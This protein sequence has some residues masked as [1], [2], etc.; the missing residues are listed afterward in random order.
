MYLIFTSFDRSDN[1]QKHFT[2]EKRQEVVRYAFQMS[3]LKASTIYRIPKSTVKQ[4]ME[5]ERPPSRSGTKIGRPICN[6]EL[7]TKVLFLIL[8]QMEKGVGVTTEDVRKIGREIMEE[9][10]P[11]FKASRSWLVGFYR[12]H[13]LYFDGKFV[14]LEEKKCDGDGP[15]VGEE[16]SGSEEEQEERLQAEHK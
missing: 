3:V 13:G 12:R 5:T 1:E 6:P 10:V 16:Y 4:W 2:E 14:Q 9:E 11:A 7:E 8:T 15:D